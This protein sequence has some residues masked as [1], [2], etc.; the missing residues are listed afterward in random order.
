[1]LGAS[2]IKVAECDVVRRMKETVINSANFGFALLN[3]TI[4]FTPHRYVLWLHNQPLARERLQQPVTATVVLLCSPVAQNSGDEPTDSHRTL[5]LSLFRSV[6]C[7]PLTLL[8]KSLLYTDDLHYTLHSWSDV[9]FSVNHKK[10]KSSEKTSTKI[11][12]N[13]YGSLEPGTLTAILGP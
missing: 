10:T 12:D 5:S 1:M 11:L 8:S 6:L 4:D 3:K 2:I 13:A 9:S 7:T